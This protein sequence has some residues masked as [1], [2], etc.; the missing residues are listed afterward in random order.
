MLK[1]TLTVLRGTVVA[2]VLGF[3][4]LPLLTRL[5]TP[6]AFGQLQLYQASMSLLLVVAAMRFEIALLS[7]EDGREVASTLHLCMITNVLVT[8]CVV[9]VCLTLWFVPGLLS[10]T[11]QSVLVWLPLGVLLGGTVQTLG[12]LALR[13]KA[14][15]AGANAK[16]AQAGGYVATSVGFGMIA[17][18]QVGLVVGDLCGRLVSILTLIAHRGL[19][20]VACFSM[21]RTRDLLQAARRFREFPLVSVPGGL[22]NTAG[23]AMTALLMYGAFD[24]SV[25]GQYG[26]VERSLMLP[27]GM[28][29]VAVSQVFTANLSAGMRDGSTD[30]LALYRGV[31]RRMFV[32]GIGPAILVG[33]F[34][35]FA[36]G[37][38]F[39]SKWI[40]A[41]E[42]ARL[43]APLVLVSLITGAVNM[44][45]MIL[46]WQKVQLG[47][48][49]A[50]LLATSLAWWCVV[51]Y[52]LPAETAIGLHVLV[53]VG[54]N[55]L[56]LWLADHMLRHHLTLPS[57]G[58]NRAQP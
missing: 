12:Y 28:V 43:M 33:V 7:A 56:Y 31:V 51:R 10:D 15:A 14:F 11:T 35:P 4:A 27:V 9:I 5:F 50:R 29:A 37:L 21:S 20:D 49:L 40:M 39:G 55:L 46:G 1:S 18:L 26:L 13:Q 48:E 2:Q 54:M 22:I 32:L 57:S 24:A 16:V 38:V 42:F 23:G 44:A 36:F 6:E 41:G 58:A 8:L 53:S 45:L 52:G 17:P 34:S 25:A 19:F 30:A 47:W 3:L